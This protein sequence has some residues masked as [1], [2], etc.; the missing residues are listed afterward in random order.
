MK[1]R[2]GGGW[3]EVEGVCGSMRIVDA[4]CASL[5][6]YR[7]CASDMASMCVFMHDT[8]KF[9]TKQNSNSSLVLGTGVFA[10][11]KD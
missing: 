9:H 2:K 11:V 7:P 4:S 1:R 5:S 10:K 8:V 3:L 6:Q